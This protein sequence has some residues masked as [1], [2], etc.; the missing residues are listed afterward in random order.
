MTTVYKGAE[1]AK[2]AQAQKSFCPIPQN[3]NYKNKT[4]QDSPI[5]SQ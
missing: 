4:K 5:Q 1:T 2:K 3:K